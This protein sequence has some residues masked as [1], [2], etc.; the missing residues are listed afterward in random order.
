[1]TSR[2][3]DLRGRIYTAAARGRDAGQ[4]EESS[5]AAG[6]RGDPT[7]PCLGA[8]P[9]SQPHSLYPQPQWL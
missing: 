3:N 7:A 6:L 2:V 9:G 5:G 8:Q 4:Q 1:M